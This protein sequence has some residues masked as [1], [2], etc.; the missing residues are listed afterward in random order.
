MPRRSTSLRTDRTAKKR[1]LRNVKIKQALKKTLKKFYSLMTAKNI[2]EAKKLLTSAFSQLDKAAKKDII[3][4]NTA[5]RKKS[6][7]AL[8]LR[9]GA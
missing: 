2:E 8:R 9:K 3:H 1:H 6:R 5:H 4:P 7:L